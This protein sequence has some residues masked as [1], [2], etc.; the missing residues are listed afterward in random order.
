M[1]EE[2][3]FKI[4][5][6]HIRALSAIFLLAPIIPHVIKRW[7]YDLNK[8]DIKFINNY[9]KYWNILLIFFII[10]I[11]L[12]IFNFLNWYNPFLYY[13]NYA[14][15]LWIVVWIVIW[16]FYIFQDKN[17]VKA[18]EKI[19]EENKIKAWNL[20]IIFYYLPL[21]NIFLRYY[22]TKNDD[23]FRWIKESIIIL[24]FYIACNLMIRSVF[25]NFVFVIF[26]AFRIISLVWWVDIISNDIKRELNDFFKKNP[27]EIFGYIRWSI[28][29][30]FEKLK[31]P[32]LKP[33]TTLPQEIDKAKKPYQELNYF[34]NESDNNLSWKKYNVK[35]IIEYLILLFLCCSY[36]YFYLLSDLEYDLYWLIYSFPFLLLVWRY[37]IMFKWKKL[38]HIPILYEIADWITK[39]FKI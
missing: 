39:L 36:V 34:Q 37:L 33:N 24:T 18:G 13:L 1:P 27:E 10:Y 8:E 12:G 17:I 19:I 7:R 5:N 25:I 35:I 2:K 31:A 29:Y 28:I 6:K 26:F 21:Y 30:L 32:N 14:I 20:D 22:G 11:I 38:P 4:E 9:I 15:I 16:I 3:E 23:N